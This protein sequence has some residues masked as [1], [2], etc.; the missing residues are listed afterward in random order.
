M[1]KLF[2]NIYGVFFINTL[3]R[4][5]KRTFSTIKN[6]NNAIGD[7]YVTLSPRGDWRMPSDACNTLWMAELEKLEV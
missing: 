7:I 6:A 2:S 1:P 4:L 5:G 3:I